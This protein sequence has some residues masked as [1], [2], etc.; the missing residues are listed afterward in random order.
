MNTDTRE[1]A[2]ACIDCGIEHNGEG[3]RCL[4][5][6]TDALCHGGDVETVNDVEATCARIMGRKLTALE[7]GVVLE[8]ARD[9]YGMR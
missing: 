2:P 7:S 9:S 8:I 5:C 1:I 6:L 4:Y 3:E